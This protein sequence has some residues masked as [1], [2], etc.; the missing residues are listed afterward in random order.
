MLV[1]PL[2]AAAL[3]GCGS[4]GESDAAADRLARQEKRIEELEGRVREDGKPGAG[5]SR[6]SGATG[7]AGSSAPA[8]PA[9]RAASG[10]RCAAGAL[11]VVS[12]GGQGA[13][14]TQFALLRFELRGSGACT[15]TGYPGVT[16]L[17]DGRRLDVDVGRF[18]TGTPKTVRVDVRHPAYFDVAYRTAASAAPDERPCRGTVTDLAVIP[19]DERSALPVRLR[20]RPARLC[21]GSVRVGAVRA[22]SRLSPPD[23]SAP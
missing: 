12:Y 3:A 17:D 14:G 22:T 6:P 4:D 7:A 23:D 19:P 16:V 8:A 2:A 13:A 21:L 18:S 11:R 5:A 1:A 10:S 9:P 15:L 20:P